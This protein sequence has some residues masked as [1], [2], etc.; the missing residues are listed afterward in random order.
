MWRIIIADWRRLLWILLGGWAMALVLLLVIWRSFGRECCLGEPDRWLF[1]LKVSLV[2][3]AYGQA[4]AV[5]WPQLGGNAIYHRQRLLATLPLS[6]LE[7]NL[8]HY[9]TGAVFLAGGLPFWVATFYIWRSFGLAIEPWL[10]VFTMLVIIDF[11]LLSMRN[12]FPRVLIPLFF[13]FILI[14]G[15]EHL[16]RVPLEIMTTPAASIILGIA[17]L[18]FAWWVARQPTPFWTPGWGDRSRSRGARRYRRGG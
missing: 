3:L 18:L 5:L 1:V 2:A 11:L 10:A 16:L 6:Q 12:L 7:L 8:V 14:P 15:A 9:L 17:T 13:P 4:A